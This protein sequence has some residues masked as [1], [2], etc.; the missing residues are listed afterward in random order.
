[1]LKVLLD[2]QYHPAVV[3]AHHDY[4]AAGSDVITIFN[5]ACVPIFLH[6]AGKMHEMATLN[7]LAASLAV[8]AVETYSFEER[9]EKSRK[10]WI[11]GALPTP[12]ESFNECKSFTDEDFDDTFK[13]IVQSIKD[14]VDFFIAE[15]FAASRDVRLTAKAARKYAPDKLLFVSFT[16]DK[17]LTFVNGDSVE[18]CVET[19]EKEMELPPDG[20]GV[21]CSE[22][23]HSIKVIE[24]MSSL[25]EKPLVA[26]PNDLFEKEEGFAPTKGSKGVIKFTAHSDYAEWA[27]HFLKTKALRLLG[28][29]CGVF[30]PKIREIRKIL[31]S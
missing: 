18:E 8:K 9:G 16:V 20:Y 19:M 4:I 26:Y 12:G 22:I 31:D 30:P 15:T 29:C 24:K 11:A 25:V 10:I 6:N 13:I 5:Y 2:E 23:D 7:Q 21:N 17:R 1:M 3:K 14:H 28:G 27:K